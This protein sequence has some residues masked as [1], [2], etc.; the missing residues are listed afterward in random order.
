M[1]RCGQG[2]CVRTASYVSLSILSHGL[3]APMHR[4]DA[5]SRAWCCLLLLLGG[6]SVPALY[7]YEERGCSSRALSLLSVCAQQQ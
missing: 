3:Q 1:V 2:A 5:A 4:G 6:S 7:M